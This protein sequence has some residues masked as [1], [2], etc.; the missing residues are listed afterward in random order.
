MYLDV[1]VFYFFI[2]ISVKVKS[3][4]TAPW[5]GRRWAQLCGVPFKPDLRIYYIQH[6]KFIR[7]IELYVDV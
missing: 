1:Y 3:L 4:G 6:D 2:Q 7:I 5:P